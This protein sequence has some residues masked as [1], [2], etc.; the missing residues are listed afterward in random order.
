M[1]NCLYSLGDVSLYCSY[2]EEQHKRLD[3]CEREKRRAK[4]YYDEALTR[5]N[6][7]GS[8]LGPANCHRGRGDILSGK[9]RLEEY[10]RSETALMQAFDRNDVTPWFTFGEDWQRWRR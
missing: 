3:T 2:E 6:A 1:A 10:E 4:K 7:I 9:P 8:K 5:Y